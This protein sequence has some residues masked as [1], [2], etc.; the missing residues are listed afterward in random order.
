MNR[1]EFEEL[2]ALSKKGWK[3]L[4]ESG[5]YVKPDCF[6]GFV[7]HC[8]ACEI[9]KRA[10]HKRIYGDK[11]QD[12]TLCPFDAW[13]N[14]DSPDNSN[15]N[16]QTKGTVYYEWWQSKIKE[17]KQAAAKQVAALAWTYLPEYEKVDVSDLLPKKEVKKETLIIIPEHKKIKPAKKSNLIEVDYAE[18]S[19]NRVKVI[20]IRNCLSREEVKK[21][22]GEAVFRSMTE[23]ILYTFSRKEI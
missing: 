10:G 22:Y 21:K 14:L 18:L 17:N 16:C 11:V 5:D 6:N 23:K 8:V 3:E 1:E 4:S 2:K 12:C 19:D 7:Y 9:A 15:A 13:R 20:A